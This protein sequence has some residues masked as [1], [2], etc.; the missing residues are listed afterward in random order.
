VTRLKFAVAAG[1]ILVASLITGSA[2]A[3]NA[4]LLEFY[5][6]NCRPCQ[7]MKPTL[8]E[9]EQAGVPIRH[10]DVAA[11]PH[12]ASRYGIRQTP[13][14]IVVSAGQEI[15]RL[16]GTQTAAQLQNALA[17]DPSGP[18]IPTRST[19]SLADIPTPQTR[20]APIQASL[21]SNQDGASQSR[22]EPMPSLSVADAVQ[23]AH[24]ATVRLRVFDGNGY[25]AGTGTIIDVHGEDALVLTCGHLFRDTKGQGKVEVDLFVGGQTQTVLGKVLDYDSET[26]DMALVQIRPGFP[27][28][29]IRV[30]GDDRLV[31]NGTP[32][33]SFGCDHGDDPSRRDTR[34]TGINEI[35]QHL[36]VSNLKI[37]G[38]PVS[39]R[40]GGGLFDNGGRLIG[41]CN[42]ADY[43]SDIGIYAGPGSIRW[44]LER[45]GLQELLSPDTSV[46]AAVA[47]SPIAA[48]PIQQ[49]SNE[50]RPEQASPE[51]ASQVQL[52]SNQEVIVIVRDRNNPTATSQVMTLRDPSQDLLQ[53][54]QRQAK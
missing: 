27:V 13:T 33:F 36:G 3:A 18:L 49:Y 43:K 38:A 40:S 17:I 7:A 34:V 29:P 4:I 51:Q 42:S 46:A 45:F 26:R 39:G 20:L 12:M 30:I 47:E 24:A 37:A 11:E 25:G 53:M 41:V 23:R 6:P 10:I 9:M 1:M 35:N 48:S 8:A 52:A 28:E 31:Q 5:S 21:N 54:I 16:V 44:Q 50:A 22:S 14:F 19:S 32:A 15:T 2:Q